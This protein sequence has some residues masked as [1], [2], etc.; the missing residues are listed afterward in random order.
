MTD[1]FFAPP[2]F[3]AEEALT[4]LKRSLREWRLVERA[5]R[6]ELHGRAVVEL[7]LEA[8]AI[9]ARVVRQ[10]AQSPQWSD[11]LL[12]NS[13]DIRRFGDELKQL[14][15]RWDDSDD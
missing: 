8:G 12:R 6:F 4:T 3:K 13:A 7:A 11:K 2:P 10:P 5:G 1:D 9:R 14:L 15:A